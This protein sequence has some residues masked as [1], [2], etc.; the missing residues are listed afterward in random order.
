[1]APSFPGPITS[2][3]Q[4]LIEL[5]RHVLYES[6]L[7]HAVIVITHYD[8]VVELHINCLKGHGDF[9]CYQFILI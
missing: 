2:T 5:I 9:S 6:M 4:E 3:G 1:M 8:V 7:G